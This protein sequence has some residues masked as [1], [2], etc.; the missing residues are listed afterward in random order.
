MTVLCFKSN[1]LLEQI[2]SQ[3]RMAVKKCL[4]EIFECL[5]ADFFPKAEQ[6]PRKSNGRHACAQTKH[7]ALTFLLGLEG[8]DVLKADAYDGSLV[9]PHE[10]T[11]RDLEHG[12][13]QSTPPTTIS[14]CRCFSTS[15]YAR[16]LI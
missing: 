5:N 1:M 6:A 2:K 10:V 12:L 14:P 16:G 15:G 8:I 3:E 9:E 13:Q 11:R 4:R 7:G